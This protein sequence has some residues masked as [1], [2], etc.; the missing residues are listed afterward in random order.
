MVSDEA[1]RC[2]DHQ[3]AATAADESCKEGDCPLE[4]QQ[5]TVK[6]RLT[7][8]QMRRVTTAG[9]QSMAAA[10]HTTRNVIPDDDTDSGER[11]CVCVP[12]AVQCCRRQTRED[13][14]PWLQSTATMSRT[15]VRRHVWH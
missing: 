11:R 12:P 3:P 5:G 15:V 7:G 2:D 10:E 4:Y 6:L 8:R 13:S 9:L 1:R 14:D